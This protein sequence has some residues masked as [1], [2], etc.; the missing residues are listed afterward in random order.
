[1]ARF[2]EHLELAD[3]PADALPGVARALR[4]TLGASSVLID[5]ATA[6]D[7]APAR[8][9]AEPY[10]PVIERPLHRRGTRLARLVIGAR[11]PGESYGSADLALTEVLVRQVALM[12]DALRMAAALQHSREAIVSA[13][14]EERRRLRRELHDGLG[15]ALA[16]IALTLLAARN[17]GGPQ[18]DELVEGAREQTQSAVA[19]VRRLVRGL[20]PPVLEDLGLAA[21]LRAHADRLGPLEVEF[22]LPQS[23]MTLPAAVELA[24][25]RIA[26]EALTNV[27]RHAHARHCRVCL[28]TDDNEVALSVVDDGHGLV[29]DAA[30]G[31]GLRSMRERAAEL[32]GRVELAT[33]PSGGLAVD[34]RLPCATAQ[35]Q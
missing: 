31:V 24:L 29:S 19:D 21:A 1:V 12:L 3:E 33:G 22:E 16:G 23:P 32:G 34:V 26:T 20:R 11:A 35:T 9:G 13:R 30:P 4:E 18:G 10:E 15:S 27:V 6:L 2:T 17:T 5:P 14:E 25:Y 8:S 28:R 7:L